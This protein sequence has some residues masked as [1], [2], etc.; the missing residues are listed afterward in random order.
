MRHAFGLPQALMIILLVSGIATVTMK[1]ASINAQHYADSYTR[2]QAELFMQSVTEA[3]LLRISAYNRSSGGCM[4]DLN[5]TSSDGKFQAAIIIERY[6]L[7]DGSTCNNVAFT[8][9]QSEESHG[10]ISMNIVVESNASN[11]KILHSIR[12]T[13]RSLQRP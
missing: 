2:E 8:P 11:S 13:R 9:I 10:M 1:Y 12:L 3:T 5:I 6:Y 4:S 7:S